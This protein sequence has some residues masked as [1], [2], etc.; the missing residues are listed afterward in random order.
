[1]SAMKSNS[2]SLN[3][4]CLALGLAVAGCGKNDGASTTSGNSSSP[5]AST[6]KLKLAFVSNNAANF[7][8]IARRGCEEAEKQLGNVEVLFRIPPTGSAAEQQ[9][10]LA[11]L[12]AAGLDGLAVGPVDPAKVTH[13]L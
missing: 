10:I 9:Q 7:W 2:P 13:V 1:M 4:L 11:D 3:V 12:L 8:T 5:A 6:K